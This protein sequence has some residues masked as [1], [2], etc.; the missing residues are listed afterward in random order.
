[1][2]IDAEYQKLRDLLSE[3]ISNGCTGIKL[4]A[5]DQ[6]A[7]FE[8]IDMVHKR[9][10]NGAVPLHV[11]I[12][13]PDARNDI[14]TCLEMGVTGII[15]P[16]VESPFGVHKFVTAVEEIAGENIAK[17]LFL[18]INLESLSAYEKVD[19]IL[20]MK[21][22]NAIDEMVVGTSDLATSVGKPKS[23]PV[24]LDIVEQM[25]M[26]FK[27]AGKIVRVG[28]LMTVFLSRQDFADRMIKGG[29]VDEVNTSTVAID[30]KKV[31]DLQSAYLKAINFEY[32]LNEFWSLIYGK[33]LEQFRKKAA[34]LRK[35]LDTKS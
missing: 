33:R 31:K 22:I 21:E 34:S 27:K 29:V 11:K 9:I 14:R 13:G 6:G 3:L 30:V 24:V 19:D 7:P 8:F 35:I 25:C 16:M 5:E 1:M 32:Q 26:K 10:I 18:S 15:A 17:Q 23:D 4:S 28:G 20:M 2:Q 12:G